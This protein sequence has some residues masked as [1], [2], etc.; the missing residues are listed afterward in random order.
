MVF[1]SFQVKDG[2]IKLCDVGHAKDEDGIVSNG[3]ISG[4]SK[5]HAPEIRSSKY[6]RHTAKSDI[7]SLGLVFGEIWGET[8]FFSTGTPKVTFKNDIAIPEN[9][10]TAIKKVVNACI[11]LKREERPNIQTILKF[12]HS[13]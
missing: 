6:Q 9:T 3:S 11:C 2:L 4:S 1:I 10:K 12:L 8:E 7:Y 13:I 5:Y